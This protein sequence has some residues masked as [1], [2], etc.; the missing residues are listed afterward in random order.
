MAE[1][2][3]Y[4]EVLGVGRNATPE[5][6]K[7]AYKKLAKKYHPDLNPDSKTAEEKFKEVSE[8]YSVLS[9]DNQR[10]RYD[11]F[12]HE[13]LNGQGMGG[14]GGFGGFGGQGFDMGDIFSSFFG[15]GFGGQTR[16]PSAPQRGGDLRLDL[17]VTFE[18]AAKGV[19]KEVSVTRMEAC[20]DCKGSGAKPGTGRET[21]SQCNGSGRVR[22]NQ[23]TPFGQFQTVKTCSACGG[24]GSIIKEPCPKCGGSG[25]VRKHHKI[26]VNVPAGVDNGSRLRMQ[27][28]GEGGVNGGSNGDLFIYVTV[29][30][31]KF[32]KREGDNVFLEQQI[33][34]AEA[35]LGADIEVPTLDGP[36]KLTIPE[37]TQTGTTFRLRGRGFPKLRGYG[38]GDQHVRVKLFT[39]QRLSDEQKELLRKFDSTYAEPVEEDKK[40]LFGKIFK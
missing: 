21:C 18:E 23:T 30:P 14:F 9:D 8:A 27:G 31:H 5:E 37:G 28:E 26:K 16:D 40:G 36:V 13:G 22:L 19:E 15:G 38:R 39:P 2:R 7:K 4:Y 11:Q 17:T 25:R 35:A 10:A 33:S 12:G 3:D 20:P 6:I 1:K 32:F 24:S 34:F 29:K